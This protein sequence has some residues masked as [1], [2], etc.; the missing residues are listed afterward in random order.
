[1]HKRCPVS[2]QAHA[3]LK[4]VRATKDFQGVLGTVNFDAHGDAIG[5]SVGLFRVENGKFK[6]LEEVKS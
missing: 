5:K 3:V 1:M 4:E 6:F 2:Q